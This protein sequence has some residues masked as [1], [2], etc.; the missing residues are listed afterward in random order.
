MASSEIY[1]I[2]GA[3]DPVANT[4]K[5]TQDL[6]AALAVPRPVRGVAWRRLR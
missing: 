1:P 2:L 4:P 5:Y 3:T 6:K